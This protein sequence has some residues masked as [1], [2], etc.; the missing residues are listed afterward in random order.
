MERLRQLNPWLAGAS[1]SFSIL[2]P[3]EALV[4][5][6]NAFSPT[7]IATYPT[8]AALLAEE[9]V[10]GRLQCNVREIWT[11]GESLTPVVRARVEQALGCTVRNSYGASEFLAIGWECSAGNLHANAD[12]VILEPVD[13]HYRPMPAGQ[14]SHSVL[15]THL[16]NTAQPLIRYDLGD[17]VR[18]HTQ[19]CAC[20]SPLPVMEVQGR[21][22]DALVMKGRRGQT[23]TLLP[24]ALTTVLE[25][26]A[27][28]FDFQ[29]C[30]KNG[31]TVSLRV[32]AR[33]ADAAQAL[34][35]CRTALQ[36]FATAQGVAPLHVELELDQP[37][38]RGRSGKVCRVMAHRH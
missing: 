25:E 13:E 32:G 21:Q 6:L 24:L 12:W 8:A 19:A 18:L 27:G 16:A 34:D 23:V 15:L 4:D 37:L 3:V 9:A 17:Q 28:V 26:Q 10:Q 29:L 35:R 7:V 20:G 14:A 2:Q 1:R 11:G 31:H 22:D 38:L 33:G 5:A 36:A 30:Q